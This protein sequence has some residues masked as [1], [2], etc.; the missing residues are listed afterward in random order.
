[1]EEDPYK[2]IPDELDGSAEAAHARFHLAAIVDSADDAIIS[3][4]LNSRV[5]SWNDAARRL[6]G[7][8]REEMIGESILRVIPP[9]LHHQEDDILRRLRV[10]ERIQHYETTRMK[11]GGERV[12]VAL[13]ISPIRDQSGRVI[14]ASKIVRDISDRKRMERLLVQTEKLAATGR[15]AASIA[16]EINNPLEALMNLVYLARQNS[17]E[18][19]RAYRY[20]I[21]AED[22][23]ERLSHVARQ[24]LG[25]Y[26]D[27]G[28]P[29]EVCLHDVI[30]TVLAVYRSKLLATGVT[31]DTDFND[32]EKIVVSKGEMIQVFS[33][34]I[35]NAA[36]AM[37]QGGVLY[38]S[39]QKVRGPRGDGIQSI[40]RDQGTG[41]EQDNLDK[42]FE[43]FFTTKG[44]LGTGIGL[45]VAKQLVEKRGGEIAISS[46]TEPGDSGT[47]ATVFI[48]FLHASTTSHHGRL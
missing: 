13:T 36:D 48:P 28:A 39:V 43:P 20:L 37:R 6:F 47:C 7:Y 3:K 26:R 21:T 24:M 19:S 44:D 46:S 23:L 16:H 42:I 45:W 25:Y 41:I 32:A 12:E 34:L 4:D 15:M 18:E 35:T 27:T 17:H 31:V 11:K 14:G 30:E 40:V 8:T 29:A 38:L 1:V 5:R 33:N 22:E 9:E 10:G 2:P